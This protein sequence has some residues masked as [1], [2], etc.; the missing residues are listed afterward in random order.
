MTILQSWSQGV[1]VWGEAGMKKLWSAANIAVYGGG[2][3]EREFLDTLSALLGDYDKT[4]RSVSTG[5]HNRNV[6]HQLTRERI[7]DASDLA[8]MPPGR[9]IVFAAGARPTLIATQPWMTSPHAEAVRASIAN[10][11]PAKH[12]RDK[13][14][15]GPD[16]DR[17]ETAESE[18]LDDEELANA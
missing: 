9:A 1:D 15:I 4:T 8:A 7:M 10:H 6:T 13:V 17:N 3:K 12:S 18:M 2:V 5:R 11:D 14:A 16:D